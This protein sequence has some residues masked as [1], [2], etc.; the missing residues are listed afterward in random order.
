MSD[1][2]FFSVLYITRNRFLSLSTM[3]SR[4]AYNVRRLGEVAGYTIVRA[5]TNVQFRT[6]FAVALHPPLRQTARCVL[7]VFSLVFIH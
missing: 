4:L 1:T 7:A 3:L 2:S 5:G 6:T